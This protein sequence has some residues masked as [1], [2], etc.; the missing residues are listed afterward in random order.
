MSDLFSKFDDVIALRQG[1]LDSGCTDPFNL[2]MERV[3]SPTVAICNG[4]RT[5]L[6]GT[7]NYMPVW[8]PPSSLDSKSLSSV[9]TARSEKR[10]LKRSPLFLTDTSHAGTPSHSDE[11]IHRSN[12]ALLERRRPRTVDSSL[13]HSKQRINRQAMIELLHPI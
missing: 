4:K 2:V 11:G 6:L 9:V 1:L 5:I 8:V 12:T 3:E 10:P 7:Y 13:I